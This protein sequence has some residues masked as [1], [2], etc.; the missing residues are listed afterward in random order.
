MRAAG[1]A[2]VVGGKWLRGL[3]FGC[4]FFGEWAM[5]RNW[6]AGGRVEKWSGGGRTARLVEP[7][8]GGLL[9]ARQPGLAF[10][11]RRFWAFWASGG[12]TCVLADAFLILLDFLKPRFRPMSEWA[13]IRPEPNYRCISGSGF[14]SKVVR[15]DF[16]V[17]RKT[18]Y[19]PHM[20]G[21]DEHS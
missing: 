19:Q 16:P 1:V 9:Q 14:P 6:A 10:S 13:T 4:S 12:T 5:A 18:S 20:L 7:P 21:V 11:L 15:K 17:R 3:E 8:A 2:G